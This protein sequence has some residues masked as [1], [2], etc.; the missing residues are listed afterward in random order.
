MSVEPEK[1]EMPS[2]QEIEERFSKIKENLTVNLDDVDPKLAE[3]LENTTASEFIEPIQSDAEQKL[4]EVEA[5]FEALKEQRDAA[6]R[7]AK[8]G[9]GSLTGSLDTDTTNKMGMG[10]VMA[11]TIIGLP[12][13]GYGIGLLINKFS[14]A[15]GW[16]IWTTM[17]FSIL[18]IVWVAH[19]GAQT[20]KE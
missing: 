7:K 13:V 3:I 16:H 12:L 10:F 1:P 11:Y 17:G 2:D 5:R 9:D 6:L 20:N 15:S 8:L 18:A 4:S 14:G 19:L